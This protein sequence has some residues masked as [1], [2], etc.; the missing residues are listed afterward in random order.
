MGKKEIADYIHEE[1][2]LPASEAIECMEF[3]LDTMKDTLAQGE[4]LKIPGFD[5]FH[6]RRKRTRTGRNPKTGAE[7][8]YDEHVS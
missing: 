6:V 8:I 2:G 5:T 4:D 1:T 7:I 3:I